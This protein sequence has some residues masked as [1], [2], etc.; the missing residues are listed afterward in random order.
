MKTTVLAIALAVAPMMF[1]GQTTP[2][3]S[4]ADQT[5]AASTKVK[6][7]KKQHVKKAR[8]SS[9]PLQFQKAPRSAGLFY[10]IRSAHRRYRANSPRCRQLNFQKSPNVILSAC[11]PQ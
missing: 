11:S 8:P 10:F 2:A 7:V 9:L 3:K 6:K 4:A 1:A 5:T